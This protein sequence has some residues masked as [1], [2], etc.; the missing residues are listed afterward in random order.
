[1]RPMKSAKKAVKKAAI[2]RKKAVAK[3]KAAVVAARDDAGRLVEIRNLGPIVRADLRMKN[4]TV[5]AGAN[6]TGKT[7]ASKLLHSVFGVMNANHLDVFFQERAERIRDAMR[8]LLAMMP[9]GFRTVRTLSKPSL[10]ASGKRGRNVVRN[11]FTQVESRLDDIGKIV[12]SLGDKSPKDPDAAVGFRKLAD[13]CAALESFHRDNAETIADAALASFPRHTPSESSSAKKIVRGHAAELE[14]AF[15]ALANVP[16]AEGGDQLFREGAARAFYQSVASNFQFSPLRLPRNMKGGL[17][18]K[19][20]GVANFTVR[21]ESL[22]FDIP[23]EGIDLA[24]GQSRVLFLDSPVYWR[25][26]NPLI[27]SGFPSSAIR[28]RAPTMGG[29]VP[30]YFHDL[31]ELLNEEDV[32]PPGFPEL[33]RELGGVIGGKIVPRQTGMGNELFFQEDKLEH[34]MHAT[35]TGVVNLGFLSLLLEK[36]IVEKDAY[37]FID[38]PESNLHPEWQVKMAEALYELARAGVKIVLATHSIDILKRLEI[39]AKEESDAEEL[40]TVNHFALTDK[41][42]VVED[43]GEPLESQISAVMKELSSRFFNLYVRGL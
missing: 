18:I 43:K 39:H 23:D 34:P 24:R 22:S 3:K 28:R 1:M 5:L 13:E 8:L 9:I 26:Q 20:E 21:G 10:S 19:V 37:V 15:A 40:M 32:S 16:W 42:A 27:R 36:N 25:L 38:E 41:G 33:R 17:S 11:F 6:K 7:F 14:S 31:V 4:L 2:A 12:S 35:A 29:G 30:R